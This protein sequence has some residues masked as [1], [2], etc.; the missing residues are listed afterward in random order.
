MGGDP[1]QQKETPKLAQVKKDG[2]EFDVSFDRTTCTTA[3]K[4]AD[5]SAQIS[6]VGNAAG[7]DYYSVA[8]TFPD[9]TNTYPPASSP[10][11]AIE[12]AVDYLVKAATKKPE[13]LCGQM[14]SY[15]KSLG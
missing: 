12:T 7:S 11:A 14:E 13:D 5:G 2:Y 4:G 10:E 8:I 3:V 15:I 1:N 6:V 9:G